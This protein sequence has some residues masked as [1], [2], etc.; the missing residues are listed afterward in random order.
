V[1]KLL[2]LP[3][4]REQP[5]LKAQ[6]HLTSLVYSPNGKLFASTSGWNYGN[7]KLWDMDTGK[8]LFTLIPPGNQLVY[9]AAF[10]W[11]SK[12]IAAACTDGIVWVWDVTTGKVQMKGV[13]HVGPVPS[14][15]FSGKSPRVLSGGADGTVRLW[16]VDTGK[17]VQPLNGS[18]AQ[19][20]A[21]SPDGRTSA[22]LAADR[23]ISFWDLTTNKERFKPITV[24][25]DAG[26]TITPPVFS[27]DGRYLAVGTSANLVMLVDAASGQ[28]RGLPRTGSV[29]T[30]AFSPKGDLLASAEGT[31]GI[32][33][34]DVATG[35]LQGHLGKE[36]N[37]S[38]VAFSP[39]GRE[40]VFNSNDHSARI[41][42]V[43]TGREIRS[44]P[45]FANVH[46]LAFAFD[47]RIIARA[48]Y[49]SFDLSPD[50]R[51]QAVFGTAGVTLQDVVTGKPM[52]TIALPGPVLSV[53]FAADGRHLATANGN[54]TVYILRIPA[55]VLPPKALTAEEA[56]QQ[57][58]DAAKKL[59]VPVQVENSIGMKLNLIPAGRF[60]MGSPEDEPGRQANEGPQHE[61]TLTRPFY[62]GIHEVTQA[63]HEKVA[64]KNPSK[65]NRDNGGGQNHPVESVSWEDASAFCKKLSELPEEKGAGRV[66][67]LPT[68]AEWEYACRAGTRTAYSF[69]DDAS[70]L[71]EYAWFAG[72]SQGRTHPAGRKQP[73][74]WGLFDVHGNIWEMADNKM[75]RGGGSHPHDVADRS[76]SAMRFDTNSYN[77]VQGQSNTGFRV[78]CEI[79]PAPAK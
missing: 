39:S 25:G 27:P 9:H 18:P 55:D 61:V 7:V 36:N 68:E 79:P 40:I 66:Y 58:V 26:G 41:C 78:V 64:G 2:D 24:S 15:A 51:V 72:N 35:E 50:G 44:L 62:I 30:V 71:G 38:A 23:T 52:S 16:D 22:I 46:S 3:A 8:E 21:F 47:G 14:I 67:R 76:R 19:R 63:Q 42:D 6:T 57:Q 56:K 28:T 17:E 11:D 77:S 69:G 34:W 13:G 54:G 43:A 31:D 37:P 59:G 32:K 60:V 48:G 65:F 29:L 33:V 12:T 70:K 5:A 49:G 75:I 4:R 74:P 73:N 10:S 20:V 53:A 1:V 45:N